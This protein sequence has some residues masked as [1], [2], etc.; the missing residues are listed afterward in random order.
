MRAYKKA[1]GLLIALPD[2]SRSLI[3]VF[4]LQETLWAEHGMVLIMIVV[5][6][7]VSLG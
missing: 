1:E 7:K 6:I 3:R 4:S 2:Y 5:P